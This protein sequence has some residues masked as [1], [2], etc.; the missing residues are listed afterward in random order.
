MTA[1]SKHD[2]FLGFLGGH[3][4]IHYEVAHTYCRDPAQRDDP[5]QEI[6]VQLRRSFERFDEKPCPGRD[7]NPY[8]LAAT[9][10]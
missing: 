1:A 8:G 3:K 9:N 4:R 2:A 5:I 7:L 10:T 6:V